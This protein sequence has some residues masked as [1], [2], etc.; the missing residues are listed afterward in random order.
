MAGV[1]REVRAER[2]ALVKCLTAQGWSAFAIADRLAVSER[3]VVR[4][5]REAGCGQPVAR[6]LTA[7]DVATAG[8][9][10]DDGCSYEEVAR[11]LGV[12]AWSIAV[13]YPGRSWT[14]SQV[15]A[16]GNLHKRFRA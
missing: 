6:H 15:S 16:F 4:Y 5:R 13:R 10:L 2:L 8:E 12:S 11:T 7:A 14:P 1:A 9:M 3:S